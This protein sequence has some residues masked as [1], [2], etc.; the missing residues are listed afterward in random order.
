LAFFDWYLL[1]PI[2]FDELPIGPDYL[3]ADGAWNRGVAGYLNDLRSLFDVHAPAAYWHM[4]DV[5]LGAII[6]AHERNPTLS[7]WA[8]CNAR[9]AKMMANPDFLTPSV[10]PGHLLGEGRA[11]RRATFI[12]AQ[13]K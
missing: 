5:L 1:A 9:W 4:D 7:V 13:W 12:E 8:I 6:A 10:V 3:V 2:R 11:R